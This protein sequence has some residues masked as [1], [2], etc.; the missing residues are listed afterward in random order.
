MNELKLSLQNFQS[1]GEGELIFKTGLNFII[2]QSNS[3]KSATFRALKACLLNPKGSQRFIKRGTNK[4]SVTL[5]YNGNEIEWDRTSKESNYKI[6]GEVYHKTGAS[7]AFKILSDETG[8]TKS[9]NNDILN[10]EEELQLP[11]PFGLTNADLFKLFEN[12]FC[13]SDSAVILKAAKGCEDEV[14]A[15][16]TSLELEDQKN[17][18]KIKELGK[19]KEFVNLSKLE[20]YKK[21]LEE[22]KN[23]LEVLKDGHDIIKIAVKLDNSNLDVTEKDF[24]DLVS[25]YLQVLEL[26]KVLIRTKQL[27][28]LNKHVQELSYSNK[29][30]LLTYK[31][32]ISLQ[33]TV[34]QLQQINKLKLAEE[35]YTSKLIRYEEL[36]ELKETL[37]KLKELNR[38]KLVEKTFISKLNEL[39]E[40][41]ELQ[42]YRDTLKA[43]LIKLGKEKDKA[44]AELKEGQDK[45]KEFKVCPLCHQSLKEGECKC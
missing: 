12:I 8:F 7:S 19:F 27:H 33:N 31:D 41:K 21:E 15:E 22:M 10:I 25:S 14:K 1:I 42:K 4:S 18:I 26:K 24:T 28:S 34:K 3:G 6:N 16:I 5:Y 37:R 40:L 29:N 23:R 35:T 32:L 9:D 36:I 13:V 39:K 43:N 30:L 20:K 17:Q 45:L 44:E 2:G 38:I 11:F